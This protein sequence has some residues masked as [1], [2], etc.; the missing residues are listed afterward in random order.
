MGL[1][2]GDLGGFDP[3]Q[4]LDA[5]GAAA[6]LELRQA[7]ELG[8]LH[9]DDQLPLPVDRDPPPPA[10]VAQLAGTI[11]AESR[12]QRAGLVV[13]ARVNDPAAVAG[14]VRGESRLALEQHDS[15]V[16]VAP[17]KLAGGGEA[18]DPAADDDQVALPRRGLGS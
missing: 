6:A 5:V 13:D 8:F 18:D 17:L 12:L 16:P 4:A 15:R 2:L 7:L 11:D 9:R 1:D 3:A 14:L 10:V